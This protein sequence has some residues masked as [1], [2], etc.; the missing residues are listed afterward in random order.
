MFPR[1]PRQS[2]LQA[3]GSHHRVL[4]GVTGSDLHLIK[5]MTLVAVKRGLNRASGEEGDQGRCCCSRP[6]RTEVAWTGWMGGDKEELR[7]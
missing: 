5:E 3:L 7:N 1:D 2:S 4:N 6:G